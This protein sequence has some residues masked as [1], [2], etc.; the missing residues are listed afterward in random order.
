MKKYSIIAACLMF[1]FACSKP[2]EELE[3]IDNVQLK[4]NLLKV[5]VL[6]DN[7][8]VPWDIC[9]ADDHSLWF[10]EQ[11]GFVSRIDLQTG[12]QKKLL[13]IDEVWHKRTAGLLALAVHPNVKEK[14]YVVMNYTLKRD[15]SIFNKLVRYEFDGDTLKN[16]K[17]L[18]EIDGFT[19]HNG[20]RI[21]FG[22]D[23]KI[24]WATG[25][26]YNG[27]NAQNTTSLNG[28]ILR[29]N[30][31][32]SIPK[33]NPKPHSYV[34]ASGFRN[35]QGLTFSDKGLLYTSEHGDAIEDE[36]NLIQKGANYGW[37]AIEGIHDLP[38]EKQFAAQHKTTEPI[39]SWT[40]VIA[41]AGITYYGSS[42]IGE[43]SNSLLLTTLKGKSLRVIK[44]S[45]DGKK[46]IDEEIFFE[47]YY[48]RLRDVCTDKN[49]VVY[50]ATSNKD[51]NPTPGF[52]L[53]GDDKILKISVTDKAIGEPLKGVKPNETSLLSGKTLYNNYCASCHKEDGTGLSGVFPALKASALVKAKPDELINVLLKGIPNQN[54]TAAMPAFNFLKDEE[55]AVIL[56]YIRQNWENAASP[57]SAAQIKQN[58]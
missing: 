8:N 22:P 24:Y 18:L 28:K 11:E 58:R 19:A 40:P 36:I 29:L 51:W 54:G 31:D 44:L 14:P 20:S 49:G 34:W 47:N 26:A 32:G 25:D 17:V 42:V 45:N 3:T 6:A 9:Y 27:E 23:Q 15:S 38:I 41:P 46:A 5:E 35:M 13:K 2:A 52:P 4:I 12:E 57:V 16:P 33:D 7:L 50:V 1:L 37:P 55:A 56:S 21:A 53:A 39:K 48:G 43:W 30:I 10:T